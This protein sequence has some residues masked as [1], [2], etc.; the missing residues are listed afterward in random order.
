MKILKQQV[1]SLFLQERVI[2]TGKIKREEVPIYIN[3][4][5][6]CLAPFGSERN[7]VTGLSPLKVFD[8]MACGKAIVTTDVGG[9]REF[10]EKYNIGLAVPPDNSKKLTEAIF[11]LINNKELQER[12]G[13]EGRKIAVKEFSWSKIAKE[14]EKVCKSTEWYK[15]RGQNK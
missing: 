1:K 4:A 11:K 2:F 9:L 12:F 5:D 8:Y 7:K 13:R 3:S 6:V 10:T 15:N 14:V